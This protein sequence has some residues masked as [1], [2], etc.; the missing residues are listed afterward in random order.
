MATVTAVNPS[1]GGTAVTPVSAS[2][3]GDTIAKAR[4][5][6]LV[7]TNGSASQITVTIAGVKP[8]DQGFLH[9]PPFDVAAGETEYIP[10]PDKC[11]AADGTASVT[12]SSATSVEVS[13]I[14]TG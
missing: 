7:V 2:G 10:I 12:Y 13:A 5:A 9:N 1:A 14:T 6:N 3:S 4:R 8:C 11:I